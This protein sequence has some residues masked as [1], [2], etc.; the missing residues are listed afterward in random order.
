MRKALGLVL[1]AASFASGAPAHAAPVSQDARFTASDGV[2]LQTTISGEAPL[3]PRP[4]IVEFSPYGR[5]SGTIDPGPGFNFLLVQI[6]GTGDSDGT[7]D[8][9]GPRTQADVVEVLRWACTQPWSNGNLGLNGFSAS[10]ITIYN[11]LHLQLPCVRAA[12]LKSGTWELYRDLLW[13]GGVSNA[14]VGAG[15]LGLIGA[16]ATAQGFDRLQ[17]A[18]QTAPGVATGLLGAGV[19]GGLA[20]PT[21]DGWWKHRGFRGDVNHLPI[22]MIDG[23]FD[24]ESRG[25]FQ[26]FQALRGDGAHMLVVGAHDGAPAGTD[27]GLGEARAWFDH[28]IGGAANDVEQH[29][30]VQLWMSHGSR[31]G[32]LGGDFVRYDGADW[33]VPGTRW[34]PLALDPAASGTAHS[35]NDGTLSLAPPAAATQQSY[36][37]VTSLPS[38]SDVPNTAILGPDGVNQLA[39]AFP[40]FTEMTA[41]EPTGLSYTTA[42]LKT[43]VDAAGPLDLNVRLSTTAPDTAIWAVVCDVSPDGVAHP[44]TVGRL[45][46]S[47]PKIVRA[48]SLLDPTTGAVVQPYG[49]YSAASAAT[50]GTERRY[51]VEFWPI[52]NRFEAGHRIRL[53][54]VGQS[55]ASKPGAPAVNTIEVGGPQGAQLQFPVLPGSDLGAALG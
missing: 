17:R 39:D 32:D 34:V 47:Y 21:L 12:V 49:V 50:P 8:A 36:P 37:A 54:I 31:E 22:L 24:V 1:A 38:N 25:A 18:P 55:A 33:P 45:S 46:T 42:P 14:A 48:K 6:R 41:T 2:S 15:V 28:F 20:H 40:P 4:T 19:Q 35:I 9:L 7:F 30:A 53:D 27:G 10:A 16:P 26:A 29:P 44:L 51:H 13:P 23:F 5:N 43:A 11:S 52:G 3:A